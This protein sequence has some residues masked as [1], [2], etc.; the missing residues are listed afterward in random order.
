MTTGLLDDTHYDVDITGATS[1]RPV[2]VDAAPA[3]GSRA[4]ALAARFDAARQD[5]A[6]RVMFWTGAVG[7]V[8]GGAA[9]SP[10]AGGVAAV[11]LV[12]SLVRM[13]LVLGR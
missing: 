9:A 6:G 1:P 4:H 3:V 7:G 5:T 11:L 8:A 2:A 10:G 13:G 12:G